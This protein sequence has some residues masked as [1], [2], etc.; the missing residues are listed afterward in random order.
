MTDNKSKE[1]EKTE[2]F[3]PD[4]I[5]E[6]LC[7]LKGIADILVGLG[8]GMQ[9]QI[10]LKNMLFSLG[11]WQSHLLNAIID[12]MGTEINLSSDWAKWGE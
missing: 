11:N 2:E 1:L 5:T 8:S 10:D 4:S 9:I 12:R 7:C 3:D 6:E